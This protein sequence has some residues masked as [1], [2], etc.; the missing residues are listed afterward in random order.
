MRHNSGVPEI[1]NPVDGTRIAYD[2]VGD[3]PP[4][5]LLHGSALSR[6]IWRGFGYTAALRDHYRLILVDLRGHGRSGKPHTVDGYSLDLVIGD[7]IAVLDE[8]KISRTRVLGYSFGGFVAMGLAMAHPARVSGLIVGGASSRSRKGTFDKLYFPGAI[9]ALENEGIE[10]FLDRWN[11]A[12][13][14]PIDPATRTAFMANDPLAMAAYMR[15]ADV[16]SSLP[17]EKLA[18]ITAPT[19]VFVGSEDTHRVDDAKHL[20]ATIPDA[21]SVVI[22]G[23]DHSTT[24]AAT[25]EVLASVE[26]FLASL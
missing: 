14:W 20:A 11:E 17:D 15:R 26:P 21:S 12:R 24:I 3:G 9:D 10:G 7:L 19:L 8:L 18:Q 22:A 6:A 23:H 13:S 25:K 2:V 4:L 1:E 5:L 16:E